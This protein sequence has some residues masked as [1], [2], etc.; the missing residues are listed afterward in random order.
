VTKEEILAMEA[1]PELDRLVSIGI[2]NIPHKGEEGFRIVPLYS[3][4]ISAAWQVVGKLDR[5][6]YWC[7]IHSYP[8]RMWSVRFAPPV[9]EGAT[10]DCPQ[11]S[12]DICKSALIAKLNLG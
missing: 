5:L 7:H 9:G 2:M 11:V 6:G 12:E 8:M 3:I 10:V 1:G 4:D